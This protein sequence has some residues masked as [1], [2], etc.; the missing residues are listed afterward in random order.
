MVFNNKNRYIHQLLL[1][2]VIDTNM[3]NIL[4]DTVPNNE[5]NFIELQSS[6]ENCVNDTEVI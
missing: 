4:T 6:I 5:T 3:N 2:T 1:V